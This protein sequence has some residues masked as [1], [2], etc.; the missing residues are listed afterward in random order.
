MGSMN[1]RMVLSLGA[2]ALLLG[3]T[4]VGCAGHGDGVASA[5]ARNENAAARTASRNAVNA[6]KALR[7]H[8]PAQAVVDAEAAVSLQPRNADYRVLLG[9]SYMQSGR[10]AS[11]RDALND[12]V[13]LAPDAG[14]VAGKAA[15]NLALAQIAT[16]DWA[17]ARR[18]IENHGG[19][20]APADRGLALALAGDPTGGVA[21][22]SAAA[23]S[24]DAT[25]TVRQNLALAYALSG[26][27]Q[28]ARLVASAD[29]SPADV[30]ARMEQWAAFA[31]PA[32]A[33]DQVAS[34]LGVQ[35]V[36]DG[37]QPVALALN[38]AV[39]PVAVAAAEAP[40]QT[41]ELSPDVTPPPYVPAAV[42]PSAPEPVHGPVLA[43]REVPPPVRIR[44]V[45]PARAGRQVHA[46]TTIRADSRPVKVAVAAPARLPTRPVARPGLRMVAAA[47]GSWFVQLGAYDTPGVAKDAWQRATRRLPAL[48]GTGPNGASVTTRAGQFYRLSVGGYARADAMGLCQRFRTAGGQCFVRAGAGDQIAQWVAKPTANKP[49]VKQ[50]AIRKPSVQVASR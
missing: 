11:A 40:V 39:P 27:W 7:Q 42:E 28:A 32:S 29:M 50:A 12:A 34:L 10:F 6:T 46:A 37:G 23:R 19:G 30:D 33:S 38:A 35:P 48:A 3:G 20:I 44:T 15:L 18:T 47:K 9:Q 5:S 24:G 43:A 36:E 1:T 16:G 17:A 8:N 49:A 14:A 45:A 26:Q 13:A 21:V 22:L 4:M 2:S 25:P 31:R 41:A